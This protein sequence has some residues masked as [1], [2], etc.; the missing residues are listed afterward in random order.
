[1]FRLYTSNVEDGG[2][3]MALVAT[4]KHI[5]DELEISTV[6]VSVAIPYMD[7]VYNLLEPSANAKMSCGWLLR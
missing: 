4:I 5:A 6:S 3:R 7:V 1:M 2:K